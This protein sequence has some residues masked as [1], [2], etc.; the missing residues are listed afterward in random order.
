M[1]AAAPGV[2]VDEVIES[3]RWLAS[4]DL[5]SCDAS[6]LQL[7]DRRLRLVGGFVNAGL[8]LV[9]QRSAE[10]FEQGRCRSKEDLLSRGCRRS[11]H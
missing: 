6:A 10:L 3:V 4:V 2:D 7:I 1:F 9:A 11:R 8:G 5:P